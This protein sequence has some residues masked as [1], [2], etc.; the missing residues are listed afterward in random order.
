MHILAGRE[1]DLV[2]MPVVTRA[3]AKGTMDRVREVVLINALDV[4][5]LGSRVNKPIAM[6]ELLKQK[7]ISYIYAEANALSA[8]KHCPIALID[9]EASIVFVV[10]FD[11]LFDKSLPNLHEIA[12][13]LGQVLLLSDKHGTKEA[14][15]APDCS[16]C[17]PE[18]HDYFAPTICSVSVQLPAYDI[19]VETG[20]DLDQ[21][22]NLANSVTVE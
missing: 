2:A 20:T 10:P 17:V 19:S 7:E 6:E 4:I 18:Y 14:G 1:I 16:V 9:E 3:K 12:P 15:Y 8:L 22:R 5:N 11:K 13:R 21:P